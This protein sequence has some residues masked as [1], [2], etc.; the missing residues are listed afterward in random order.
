MAA[1]PFHLT[2]REVVVFAELLIGRRA[3]RREIG[4]RI[5]HDLKRDRRTVF[6]PALQRYY[7]REVATGAVA[8]DSDAL[9]VDAK[10]FRIRRHP[11][12]RGVAVGYRRR[13]L[14]FGGEAIVY[15]DYDSPGTM[16]DRGAHYIVRVQITNHPAA[17]ME[18]DQGGTRRWCIRRVYA[19]WD[20]AI[21]AGNSKILDGA[22]R[23][24]RSSR[25]FQTLDRELARFLGRERFQRWISFGLGRL[26]QLAD[27]WIQFRAQ[28]NLRYARWWAWMT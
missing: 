24:R 13:E 28:H 25:R 12:C 10:L 3:E 19:D 1:E 8:A 21:G 11:S 4:H 6:V 17:A 20:L 23:F 18:V 27:G 2:L 16:C 15:R 26:Q 9:R 14:V 22:D 7:G 5:N